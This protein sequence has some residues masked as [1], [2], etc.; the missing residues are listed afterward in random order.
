M[1]IKL[2]VAT[3]HDVGLDAYRHPFVYEL[4]IRLESKVSSAALTCVQTSDLRSIEVRAV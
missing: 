3:G 4:S 1:N 2:P